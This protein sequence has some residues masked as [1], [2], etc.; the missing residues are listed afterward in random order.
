VTELFSTLYISAPIRR[1]VPL[2]GTR[3]YNVGYLLMKAN[4]LPTELLERDM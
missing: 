4:A 3:T 2:P 1:H